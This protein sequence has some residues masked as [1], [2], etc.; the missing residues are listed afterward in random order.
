[1]ELGRFTKALE[2]ATKATRLAPGEYRTHLTLGEVYEQTGEWGKAI[3]S[4]R[5]SGIHHN[6]NGRQNDGN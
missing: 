3:E 5:S 6:A 4:Y 1:M 2:E